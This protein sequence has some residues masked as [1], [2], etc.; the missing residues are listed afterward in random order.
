MR[1]EP[2]AFTDHLFICAGGA[3]L[4][5]WIEAFPGARARAIDQLAA[6]PAP[7]AAAAVIWLRLE[8]GTELAPMIAAVAPPADRPAA[9]T[10]SGS[11]GNSSMIWRVM[12][13]ISEGSPRSRS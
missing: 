8:A 9:N 7:A 4:P 2:L 6:A 13:A 5:A 1:N 12:P 11:T 3:L 10:R